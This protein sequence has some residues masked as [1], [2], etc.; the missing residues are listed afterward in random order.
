M[1]GRFF[2]AIDLFSG[3]GGL[4][5]GL[6]S[7]GIQ[8]I[9]GV[10]WNKDAV[11]T[12]RTH[13]PD[14]EH[15]CGDI[16]TVDFTRYSGAVDIV[17]GGPPCQPFSTGGLRKGTGDE[18]N[19]IPAFLAAVE[20]IKPAVVLMENVP[21][22]LVP[23][24]KHYFDSILREFSDRGYST[25]WRLLNSADYGVPQK[26]R[27]VFIVAFKDKGIV[28]R[29]P[30]PTHGAD[31]GVP[32]VA[33]STVV[34]HEPLGVPA[35]SAVCYAP[36][37]DIR[38]NP[39]AGHVYKGG[40]RPINLSGPCHTIYASAG[41]NKTHWVDT[42]NVVPE[43]HSRLMAGGKTREGVVPGARRLSVEES[44]LIQTFPADLQFQGSR[45]SQFTQ[46]GDAV[47]PLLAS[48]LGRALVAHL[49][50]KEMHDSEYHP[51]VIACD[52]LLW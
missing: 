35:R 4:T 23:S 21:G 27:R 38:P 24:R 20:T 32:H 36:V 17:F 2:R 50:G 34:K 13:T 33:T 5:L 48:H 6:K 37:V 16:R 51:P 42:L 45:S 18:R 26:R 11:A 15:H 44:A 31:I 28:F 14:S 19:M 47:P 9:A 7:A 10:E 1:A 25:T 41:G 46:V 29:F 49:A 12:Y 52:P 40:G 3:P 43:Y 8:P 22:M 39:Y 30:R